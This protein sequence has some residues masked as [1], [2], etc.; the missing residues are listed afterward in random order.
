CDRGPPAHLG[1]VFALHRVHLTTGEATLL[2]ENPGDVVVWLTDW[3]GQPRARLRHVEPDGRE[4]QVRWAGIWRT[5]QTFDLEESDVRLLGTAPDDRGLWL[6]SG[7]GRDRRSLVRVDL[8][9][10]AE[11]LVYEHPRVDLDRVRLSER[12][13]SPLAAFAAPDYPHA[14]IFDAGLAA[15]A[16]RLA[17]SSPTGLSI[18][19]LDD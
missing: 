18:T 14:K 1:P 7:R 19:S 17:R 9:T 3:E 13:R 10:G 16:A 5:L 8:A 11:S 4:L 12:T 2:A 15:E 6:L